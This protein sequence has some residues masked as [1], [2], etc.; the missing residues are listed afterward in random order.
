MV[1]SGAR[2]ADAPLTW[3]DCVRIAEQ[4]N[5]DLLSARKALESQRARYLGSYNGLMPQV[6]LSNSR[7]DGG[8]ASAVRGAGPQWQAQGSAGMDL[9]NLKD[10]ADIG[11]ASATQSQVSAQLRLESAALR[12]SLRQAFADVLLAQEQVNV[13]TKIRDLRKTNA[14]TVALL[15]DSGRESKGNRM[16]AEAELYQA[17]AELAQAV[18]SLRSTRVGLNHQL[19]H[20]DFALTTATGTLEAAALPPPPDDDSLLANHPQIASFEAAEAVARAGVKSAWSG[21]LPNL[22]VNYSRSVVDSKEFPTANAQWSAAGVLS[23][24][25]FGGGPTASW[26][27]VTAAKR[28]LEKTREDLRSAKLQVR[29][30]LESS[31]ASLAGSIDQVEV[32]RRFLAAASQ[33]NEEAGVRYSSGLMTF[34]DW[35]LVVSDF[36]NFERSMVQSRHDAVI[37]ESAWLKALGK[38]LEEQ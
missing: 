8:P 29:D 1:S 17:E 23:L 18:R 31:W 7:T 26:Y 2:A 19:G 32:Q 15:Y 9:F 20:D 5:P 6:T 11:S 25:I 30:T 3:E 27:A 38:G 4:R 13:S 14:R 21:V 36:V 12:F 34:E 24:P 16:K 28:T 22:S 37:A 35:E 10:Y 33:R